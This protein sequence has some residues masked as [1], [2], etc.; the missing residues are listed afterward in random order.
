MLALLL[1]QSLFLN[2][3]QRENPWLFQL[4]ENPWKEQVVE[5]QEVLSVPTHVPDSLLCFEIKTPVYEES[6]F[7]FEEPKMGEKEC[8]EFETLENAVDDAKIKKI[9]K[10]ILIGFGVVALFLLRIV[11]YLI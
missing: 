5:N 11:P 10:N 2:A 4:G 6:K 7:V 3:Q 1:L 9:A 8:V